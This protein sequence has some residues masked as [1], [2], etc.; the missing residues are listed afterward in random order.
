MIFNSFQKLFM[1]QYVKSKGPEM[2][3]QIIGERPFSIQRL[4][5][6]ASR[7]YNGVKCMKILETLRK[8]DM[9]SKG[10]AWP[11]TSNR[12]LLVQLIAEILEN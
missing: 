5:D 6:P 11:Q 2:A 9:R 8:Y 4:Y 1:Y 12:D 3:A 7:Q 10:F